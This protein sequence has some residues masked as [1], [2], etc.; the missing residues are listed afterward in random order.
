MPLTLS[1]DGPVGSRL[2]KPRSRGVENCIAIVGPLEHASRAAR[3][4][5]GTANSRSIRI[6]VFSDGV[7]HDG[8]VGEVTLGS[9][10]DRLTGL[11]SSGQIRR[12]LV[13]TPVKE[14]Q[15]IAA[16][17]R[18]LEGTAT[19]VD[20]V[21]E[22]FSTYSGLRFGAAENVCIAPVLTRPLTPTQALIKSTI[23]RVGASL[24]LVLIAPLLLFIALLVK[25]TSPGDILFR[26][27]RLGLNNEEFEILKFRTL[28][29]NN[30]DPGAGQPVKRHDR[31]V[32]PIGKILRALSLDELPQLVNVLKGDM[33]L[34]GPRPLPVD[35]KVEGTPCRE[36]PHYPA[37]H[38]VRPGITGLAQVKGSRGGMEVIG[39]L[40]K[41]LA[42]DLEYIDNYSLLLDAKIAIATVFVVLSPSNAY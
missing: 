13:A 30:A 34:I 19:D 42:Y 31:R 38:R 9:D 11:V 2:G 33:S 32:M 40:E 23:D 18:R 15:R 28:Y 29:Q 35:L 37:R 22:G 10:I 16:V 17:M 39:Q 3:R 36:F 21:L 7:I 12:V 1:F 25:L 20:L 5:N 6:E 41:R 24:I 14:H 27:R 26:Q 4:I 8:N